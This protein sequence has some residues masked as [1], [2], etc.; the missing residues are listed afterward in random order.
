MIKEYF[1]RECE[2][3]SIEIDIKRIRFYPANKTTMDYE[4]ICKKCD[5][6]QEKNDG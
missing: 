4:A 3:W 1:C 5:A 6:K 2:E